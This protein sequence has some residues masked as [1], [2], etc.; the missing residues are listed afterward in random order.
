MKFT[1]LRVSGAMQFSMRDSDG[2]ESGD[3]GNQ[4]PFL[5]RVD[6]FRPRINQDGSLCSGSTEGRGD[7]HSRGNET[8]QGMHVCA[9]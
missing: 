5:N 9:D 1:R 6:A 8:A 4:R 2:S 7:Q 3:G